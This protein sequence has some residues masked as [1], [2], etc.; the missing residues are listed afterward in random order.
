MT[1]IFHFIIVTKKHSLLLH[2]FFH[3]QM[4]PK[5]KNRFSRPKKTFLSTFF[6]QKKATKRAEGLEASL[7]G[8]ESGDEARKRFLSDGK[9]RCERKYTQNGSKWLVLAS[10]PLFFGRLLVFGLRPWDFLVDF[11]SRHGV[12]ARLEVLR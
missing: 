12:V 4:E 3:S 8:L 1:S 6:D 7:C 5:P 2:F 11:S 10:T 9:T